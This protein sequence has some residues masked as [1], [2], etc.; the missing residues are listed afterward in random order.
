MARLYTIT[1]QRQQDYLD[2]GR[3]LVPFYVI[4]YEGPNGIAGEVKVQARNAD[5]AT[6]DQLIRQALDT[7]LSIAALGDS[8]V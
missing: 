2:A 6:V 1:G 3:N 4:S 7:Q 8:E 5:A